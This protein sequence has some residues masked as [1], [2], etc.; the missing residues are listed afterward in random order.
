MHATI[1]YAT[2]E[3]ATIE[4]QNGTGRLP[5]PVSRP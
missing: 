5:A 3:Y 1:E 4:Q 2:I